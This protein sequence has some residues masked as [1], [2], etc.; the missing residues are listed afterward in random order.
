MNRTIEKMFNDAEGRY[1]EPTEQ[2]KLTGFAETLETRLSVMRSVQQHEEEMVENAIDT[3]MNEHPDMPSKHNFAREKAERDMT[4]VLRYCAMAMVR[5]DED[6]L[7]H[8]LL[9]WF[10]TIVRAFEM[11]HSID[12]AYAELMKQARDHLDGHE[13]EMLEPYLELVHQNL[14]AN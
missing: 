13:Y 12:T 14:T 2:S 4:L 11:E 9:H 6:F 1:L 7:N 10:R 8:K 5:D 3:A